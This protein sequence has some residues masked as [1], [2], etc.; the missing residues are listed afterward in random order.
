MNLLV[1]NRRT[2]VLRPASNGPITA[3]LVP[4]PEQIQVVKDLAGTGDLRPRDDAGSK[5]AGSRIV[6]SRVKGGQRTLYGYLADEIAVLRANLRVWLAEDFAPADAEAFFY[7]LSPQVILHGLKEVSDDGIMQWRVAQLGL[8]LL[9]GTSEL[10]SAITDYLLI[11]PGAPVCVAV[12]EQLAIYQGLQNVLKPYNLSPVPFSTLKPD[13]RLKPLY[14]HA[15]FTLSLLVAGLFG[16]LLMAGS[17]FYWWMT[18]HT[19]SGLNAQIDV[20][21]QEISAIHVTQNLGAVSDPQA[22]L[23]VMAKSLPVPPSGL[24]DAAATVGMAFG[25]ITQVTIGVMP[26]ETEAGLYQIT[27]DV[28]NLHEPLLIQQQ[29]KTEQYMRQWPWLRSVIRTDAGGENG[30]LVI[31]LQVGAD[32]MG[33][34]PPSITPKVEEMVTDMD[35]SSTALLSDSQIIPETVTST[36][37]VQ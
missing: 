25:K 3:L 30:V 23:S 2:I 12:H 29:Q 18:S 33:V 24:L 4:G 36:E 21:K 14:R 1:I 31:T 26:Q 9:D 11:H 6:L 20:V 35:I 10:D 15:D 7:I 8:N 28:P 19:L 13:A 17:G 34:M 27:L 32:A 22:M 16:T 5:A 37:V